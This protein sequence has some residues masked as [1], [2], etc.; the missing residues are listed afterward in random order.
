ML[1][2]RRE[3][4]PVV[5]DFRLGFTRYDHSHTCAAT[6][7]P[8]EKAG[9]SLVSETEIIGSNDFAALHEGWGKYLGKPMLKMWKFKK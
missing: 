4:F 6:V 9:L 8:A 5:I 2:T 7:G 3:L 1:C